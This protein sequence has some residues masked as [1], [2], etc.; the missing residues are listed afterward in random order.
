[1]KVIVDGETCTGCGTCEEI[2]PEVFRLENEVAEVKEDPV[3]PEREELCREAADSCPV[4]AISV[5]E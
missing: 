3:A 4:D 1:M 2:C 5:E